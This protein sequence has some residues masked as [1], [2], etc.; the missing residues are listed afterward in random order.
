M[1]RE[2]IHHFWGVFLIA[3]LLIIPTNLVSANDSNEILLKS[4]HF[5]PQRGVTVASKEAIEAIPQ[6]AHVLL[7]LKQ[8]P[9]VED[10]CCATRSIAGYL[11]R[12]LSVSQ[13]GKISS[14]ELSLK[15][16]FNCRSWGVEL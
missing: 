12:T 11:A 10:L 7:Q 6:R 14:T 13:L 5:T 4:R 8:I 3:N 9:T 15:S 16:G 1:K 2:F